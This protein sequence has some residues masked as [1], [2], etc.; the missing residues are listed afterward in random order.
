MP[1]ALRFGAYRFYFYSY[2][3]AEPR[4]MHVDRDNMSAKFWL[5]PITLA[6]NHGFGRRELREI[7]RIILDNLEVLRNEW[8]SFCGPAN[9]RN[10]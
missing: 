6:E 9:N 7:E 1:T 8:D 10:T 5:D 3:C 2:D 4:H